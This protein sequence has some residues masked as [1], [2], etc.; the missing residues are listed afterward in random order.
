MAQYKFGYPEK[1]RIVILDEKCKNC[2]ETYR[3]E[4]HGKYTPLPVVEIDIEIPIY[5]MENVRTINLQK[6]YLASHNDKPRDLFTADIGSIEAQ[7]AQHTLLKQLAKSEGLDKAFRDD[8]SLQQKEPI[9][10]SSNGI[11]VNGNRRLCVWRELFYSNPTKYK[12]F[13]IIRVAV[14]PDSD[15][16]G[17]YDLEVA[18]Q[19]KSDMKAD[20]A[21]HAIAADC[22]A[23]TDSGDL[24]IDVIAKKHG[25]TPKDI[26]EYIECYDYAEEYLES[27]GHPNEWSRVDKQFFAFKK[28]VAERKKLSDAGSK[29]LFQEIATSL[30]QEPAK[31][32]RLYNKIPKVAKYLDTITET[33]CEK[34]DVD[35]EPD[36]FDPLD[37]LTEHDNDAGT[38]KAKVAATIQENENAGEVVD[39]VGMVIDNI[40][41]LENEKKKK[42][43]VIDQI[44][45][46]SS[47]LNNAISNLD[48]SM[49]KNGVSKQI[50]SIEACLVI[51]K[52]WVK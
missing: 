42:S 40:E 4:Y 11:V 5:R 25:K 12:H 3:E 51:L 49:E 46:A 48:D 29:A 20:Y 17:M 33:L 10:C 14:L 24:E 35:I 16:R 43:F 34:Y 6:E 37:E 30:L 15:P 23:K 2:K 32:D 13:Q 9:I 44:A 26:N 22:K 7:E 28:I 39:L 31:G 52:D 50:E 47:C 45:K 36:E 21:W 1:S 27:I 8:V 41:N 19:I 38:I 18:L